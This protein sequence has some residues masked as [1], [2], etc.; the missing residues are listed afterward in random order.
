M[1]ILAILMIMFKY[2]LSLMIYLMCF[3][4]ILSGFGND[5]SLHLVITLLN[6]SFEKD[7]YSIIGL[8]GIL[9]K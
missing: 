7:I 9:S 2:K 8:D 5:K 1:H 3:H 4:E 6:S